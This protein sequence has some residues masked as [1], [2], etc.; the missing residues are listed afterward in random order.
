MD[1]LLISQNRSDGRRTLFTAYTERNANIHPRLSGHSNPR[2]LLQSGTICARIKPRSQC[3]RVVLFLLY[4]IINRTVFIN[5]QFFTF[6]TSFS[7]FPSDEDNV[8]QI[9]NNS[10]SKCGRKL[11]SPMKNYIFNKVDRK[12]KKT[13]NERACSQNAE[14]TREVKMDQV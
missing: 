8:I 14:G 5:V 2:F 11:V 12:I 9:H 6:I 10:E 1:H 7:F 13:Y 4:F 3:D